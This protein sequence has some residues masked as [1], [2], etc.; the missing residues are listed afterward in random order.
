MKV[1]YTEKGQPFDYKRIDKV[2]EFFAIK[3]AFTQGGLT[4][5]KINAFDYKA[6]PTED[7][8]QEI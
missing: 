6:I 8:M 7:I 3:K 2:T 5:Y 4:Y 1:I